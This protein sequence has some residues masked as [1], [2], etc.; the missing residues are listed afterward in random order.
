M[1]S[2]FVFHSSGKL[3][4]RA[5]SAFVIVGLRVERKLVGIQPRLQRLKRLLE[6]EHLSDGGCFVIASRVESVLDGEMY[7]S[8]YLPNARRLG[9]LQLAFH[10]PL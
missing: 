1:T 2:R 7:T 9:L 10:R 6:F 4:D 3:T 8:L 5:I